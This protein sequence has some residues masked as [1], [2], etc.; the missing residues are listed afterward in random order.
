M[1]YIAMFDEMDEGTA[2]FKTSNNPPVGPSKFERFESEIPS[3]YYLYLTGI[4]AKMLKKEIPF[5]ESIPLMPA[6][7]NYPK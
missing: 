7:N 6:Q 1:I 4:A 3:D 2:I 5:Q